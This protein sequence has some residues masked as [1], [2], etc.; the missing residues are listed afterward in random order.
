VSPDL[1]NLTIAP[2]ST[3]CKFVSSKPEDICKT[4]VYRLLRLF[5]QQQS[6][7]RLMADILRLAWARYLRSLERKPL[8]TKVGCGQGGRLQLPRRYCVLGSRYYQWF[9]R[10]LQA[11]TAGLL[12]G[13]SD[14]VAQTLT[15]SRPLHWR[16]TLAIAVRVMYGDA[17]HIYC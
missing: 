14:I 13:A 11:I 8:A 3:W 4:S 9:W 7:Q 5:Q 15:T 17:L 12:S 1:R 10:T 6:P 16:R 2:R